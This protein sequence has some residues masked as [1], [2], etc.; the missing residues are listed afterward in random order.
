MTKLTIVA[1]ALIA[2]AAFTTEA[3]AARNGA[4]RHTQ[5]ATT[6]NTD[7]NCVRAPNVGSFASVPYTVPPCMPNTA[8]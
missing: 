5:A 4:P 1:A 7:G 2:A 8:R 3:S 6:A